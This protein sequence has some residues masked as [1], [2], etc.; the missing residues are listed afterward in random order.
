MHPPTQTPSPGPPLPRRR[1]LKLTGSAAELGSVR[2]ELALCLLLS[3]VV[4]YF[5]VWKGVKS[6]GKV[7]RRKHYDIIDS[8]SV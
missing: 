5:C 4:C 8:I 3:W 1:V 7:R 6:T 2:W